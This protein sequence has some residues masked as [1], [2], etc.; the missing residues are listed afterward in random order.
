[1]EYF[2]EDE[3]IFPHPSKV[4]S[5]GILA[6][7][8]KLSIQRLWLAYNYGIFPWYNHNE[9]ILWWCPKPRFV[10]FPEKIKVP[11]SIRSYFNQNKFTVTYDQYFDDIVKCCRYIERSG[12]NGTW[13][14]DDIMESYSKLH[15]FRI[16]RSVEVW[17]GDQLVGGLYG[18]AIGKVFF[19]ESMF[20]L[21]SNASRFGFISLGKKLLEE[22]YKIIDCQQPNDYLLSLGG[23]FISG[24]TFQAILAENRKLILRSNSNDILF[25]Q[26][27]K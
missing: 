8:D 6:I 11:K 17:E 2:L 13:I 21:K 26:D 25:S 24:S 12:Q 4:K 19:G 3:I 9:P 15:Q 1:M 18:I 20:S 23:E 7:G 14:N 16:A 5:S 27:A 10:I 22:G